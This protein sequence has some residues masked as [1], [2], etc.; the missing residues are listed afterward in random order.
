MIP[1]S[2]IK[3][4]PDKSGVYFF[5]GPE[6]EIIYIGKATSLKERIRSYFSGDLLYTRSP[7]LEEM[8]IKAKDI[9]FKTTDSALEALILEANL[10]KK[11]QP[12]YNTQEKDDKSFNYIVITDEEFPRVLIERGKNISF[13]EL[14]TKNYKLQTI[15]GPFPQGN[16]LKEALKTI[17]KIFPF[18]DSCFPNQGKPCFNRQVG[19]C[20]GVCSG[21]IDKKSYGKTIKN[22]EFFLSGKKGKVVKNLESQMREEAKSK[23]FERA[24]EL[25][26]KIFALKHI[27]DISLLKR[28]FDKDYL[29][30]GAAQ[31]PFRVESY[32][33][34][35]LMGRFVVGAMVATEN[36]ELK[37]ND[38]RKF[39]IKIKPG[40]NDPAAL[41]EIIKRRL[42]HQEWPWP[43]LISVDGGVIQKRA[44]ENAA[45]ESGFGIPIV[46][47]VKD[48]RHKPKK[49]LG[50]PEITEKYKEEILKGNKEVHRFVISY[51]RLLRKKSMIRN[52]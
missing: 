30:A 35:H 25:R 13:S 26:N 41:K 2:K 46:S 20:P 43:D 5:I 6:K 51:H 18:G 14:Q 3:K 50:R 47:V 24:G 15:H 39:K 31:K 1:L 23:N 10:I 45:K 22:I 8:V 37:K 36:G 29:G 32:D 52:T 19:L 11:H 9:K 4:V 49:I 48:E 7:L 38:Y 28:D 12:K 17:R 40:I 34:A 16:L 21:E 33:V 42:N 44:A 27:Q